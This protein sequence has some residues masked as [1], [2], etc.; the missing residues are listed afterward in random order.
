MSFEV[1]ANGFGDR[2]NG[3]RLPRFGI[4]AGLA[5]AAIA[6]LGLATP[7]RAAAQND[8]G[9]NCG[10]HTLH[11]SYGLVGSGIRGLGPGVTESF[12]TLSMVTYDGNGSFTATG[13]SHGQTSGVRSGPATGTY[14]VNGDCTGGQITHI[15]GVPVPLE[16]RFVVVDSGREVRTVVVSP[17]TT[18][19][20]ANLRRK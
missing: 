15:A 10:V 1:V 14:F 6:A 11:G 3:R 17:V 5:I 20:T 4:A 2:P 8:D 13:V 16:D 12:A 7:H 19:A 18:L 9:R